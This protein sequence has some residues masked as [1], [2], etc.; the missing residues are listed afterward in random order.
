MFRDASASISLG[1]L[2]NRN[3]LQIIC[4]KYKANT[5][6]IQDKYSANNSKTYIVLL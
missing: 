6:Q 2:C 3:T 4:N 1:Q 5:R